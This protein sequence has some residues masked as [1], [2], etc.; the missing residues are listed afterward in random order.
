MAVVEA[1]GSVS[2]TSQRHAYAMCNKCDEGF[3][4]DEVRILRRDESLIAGHVKLEPAPGDEDTEEKVFI[5][6][7]K[8]AEE[9]YIQVMQ[10]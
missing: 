9:A 2:N 1:Q 4:R 5:Y 3:T 10:Q 6:C 7:P 8:A